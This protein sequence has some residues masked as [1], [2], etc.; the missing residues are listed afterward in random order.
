MDCKGAR[1]V[2]EKESQ[3]QGVGETHADLAHEH[4]ATCEEC[5]AW[6]SENICSTVLQ[7]DSEDAIMLHGMLH[8]GMWDDGGCPL[9]R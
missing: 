3:L 7:S 9:F 1:D 8:E 6:F 5:K 4:A 2:L